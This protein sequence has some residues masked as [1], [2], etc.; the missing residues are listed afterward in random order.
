MDDFVVLNLLWKRIEI[1]IFV[2]IRAYALNEINFN[3]DIHGEIRIIADG[4]NIVV[5][6][7]LH[8]WTITFLFSQGAERKTRDEERRAAKRKMTATGRKKLDELYHPVVDRSEFYAMSDVNKPPVLFSPAEDIDKVSADET[9]FNFASKN[10]ERVAWVPIGSNKLIY[11]NI[12]LIIYSQ[13]SSMELQ[14]FYGHDADSLT[15]ADGVKPS[16]FLLHAAA[17]KPTTPTLK[18]HNH[19]PPDVATWVKIEWKVIFFFVNW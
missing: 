6:L 10:M 1:C 18:F 11:V 5:T 14:G 7:L 16:P 17:N 19:F 15:G 4:Q 2:A 13:L 8:N 3:V 9:D 12:Q